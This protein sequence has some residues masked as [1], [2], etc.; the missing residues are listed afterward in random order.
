MSTYIRHKEHFGWVIEIAD[1]GKT[2]TQH[3]AEGA[4]PWNSLTKAPALWDMVSQG[5]Y[6]EIS[7]GEFLMQQ[8]AWE[9]P[10]DDAPPPSTA[11]FQRE[12]G[13]HW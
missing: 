4:K 9:L 7:E 1:D 13:D 2:L 5:R 11:E 8:T 10:E 6:I 3:S 12:Y